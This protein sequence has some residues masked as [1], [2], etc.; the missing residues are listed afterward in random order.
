M[1]CVIEE[2]ND[3]DSYDCF[4]WHLQSC[5]KQLQTSDDDVEYSHDGVMK[6]W[7]FLGIVLAM[8]NRAME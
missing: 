5:T 6:E 2:L 8:E 4:I 3:F 1:S 7:S